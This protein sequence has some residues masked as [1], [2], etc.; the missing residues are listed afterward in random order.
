MY[1]IRKERDFTGIFGIT[2]RQTGTSEDP[3]CSPF[4]DISKSLNSSRIWTTLHGD[5]VRGIGPYDKG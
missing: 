4:D 2:R 3:P 1:G 5:E